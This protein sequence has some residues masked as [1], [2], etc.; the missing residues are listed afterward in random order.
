MNTDHFKNFNVKCTVWLY[1][2]CITY[3][4]MTIGKYMNKD[5]IFYDIYN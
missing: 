2:S 3:C 5:I 1:L 4:Y